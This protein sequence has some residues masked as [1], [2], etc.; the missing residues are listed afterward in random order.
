[1]NILFACVL[2]F[3]GFNILL[4]K[5]NLTKINSGIWKNGGPAMTACS[6]LDLINKTS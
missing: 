2:I 4:S 6:S 5:A 1:M 3:L